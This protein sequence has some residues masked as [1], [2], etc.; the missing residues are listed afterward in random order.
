MLE[1]PKIEDTANIVEEVKKISEFTTAC[2]YEESVIQGSKTTTKK[3]WYGEKIDTIKHEIVLTAKC[4]V[5]AGFDLSMLGEDDLVVKGDTVSIKLPVPKVFD[6]ISNPSDYNIFEDSGD[7]GHEEIVAM[8][9]E[10]KEKVLEN[11]LEHNIL[12]KANHIG[13]GRIVTLFQGFGFNV[14]NVT[15]S[16]IPAREQ[17]PA[18]PILVAPAENAPAAEPVPAVEVVP[19]VEEQMPVDTLSQVL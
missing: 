10:R 3:H 16:D 1:S 18:E 14:I 19:A 7:W 11:A 6:V 12:E 4:K 15:L 13:K 5:R 17:A 8:Q 2:F 9:L